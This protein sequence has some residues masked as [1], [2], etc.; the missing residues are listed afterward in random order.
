MA[1]LDT[2][3]TPPLERPNPVSLDR[4][5]MA[6]ALVVVVAAGTGMALALVPS[7]SPG[8]VQQSPVPSIT[9]FGLVL[10]FLVAGLILRRSR[11]DNGVGWLLLLFGGA[12]AATALI[13]GLTYIAG[14]P[15]GNREFGRVLAWVGTMFTI[16]AWISVVLNLVVRFPTGRA[17]SPRDAR[18]LRIGA[19]VAIAAAGTAAFRPGALLIYPAFTNPFAVDGIAGEVL[20]IWAPLAIFASVIPIGAAAA[21][22]VERYRSAVLD[23]RLQL[24]WFAFAVTLTFLGMLVFFAVGIALAPNNDFLHDAT[25][26]LMVVAIGTLPVAVMQAI[27]RHRLYEIDTI[28]GRTFAYGALTAILA[29]VYAASLRGFNALFVA[30]T[31]EESEAALV[32]T[33]LVL[34]ATFTPVKSWLEKIAAKRLAAQAPGPA[35][36]IGQR[37]G[38][39]AQRAA[40][41]PDDAVHLATDPGF[42]AAVRRIVDQALDERDAKRR[43]S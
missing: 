34:A 16:P 41:A 2:T 27:L 29:G 18:L 13:W 32:L 20:A 19:Y 33:T 31:G 11:P 40:I 15:D 42:E 26:V 17:Q 10:T 39:P 21:G 5:S 43:R 6:F 25:Y 38:A 8:M 30:V 7:T 22:M 28:I 24:R 35:G 9:T 23:T 3:S 1:P 14:L 4:R 37:A 12:V 36:P